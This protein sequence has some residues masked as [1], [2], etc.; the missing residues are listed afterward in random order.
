MRAFFARGVE[1]M[2][3]PWTVEAL[4]VLIHISLFLFFAGLA[5][6]LFNINHSAFVCVISWIGLFS[7]VYGWITLMPIFWYDSPYFTPLSSTAWFFCAPSRYI[8]F[9]RHCLID[10][11][12]SD[13]IL[14]F[15]RWKDLR[16]WILGG[17]EAAAKYV[18]S[19]PISGIDLGI[20][21]WTVG[22]LGED[23]LLER[24]FEV[25][26]GFF[27]STLV[28]FPKIDSKHHLGHHIKLRDALGGFLWRTMS[29][30]SIIESVK[31]RRFDI[32]LNAVNT[33]FEPDQV[34]DTLW[35]VL[36]GDFGQMPQNIV[37]V[38]TLS[39]LCTS[40][41]EDISLVGRCLVARALHSIQ[42]RDDRWIAL[43]RDQFCFPEH[44]LQDDVAHCDDSLLLY[45]VIRQTRRVAISEIGLFQL[46]FP[47]FDICN[48]L[49][50]LQNEFCALWDEMV[51]E[52]RV[53]RHPHIFLLRWIHPFYLALHQGADAA[54]TAFDAS[55]DL[56]DPSSYPL[57]NVPA[58][59]PNPAVPSPTQLDPSPHTPPLEGQ[60]IPS[61]RT[62]PQ[63][64][65][66][67]DIVPALLSFKDSVPTAQEFPYASPTTDPVDI[68]PHDTSLTGP[69]IHQPIEMVALDSN[70]LD[71]MMISHLSQP[72]LS[73]TFD[74]L[75][76][77]MPINEA[78][79]N[80]HSPAAASHTYPHHDPV[81]V[82]V[83]PSTLLRL[84]LGFVKQTGDFLS[85][86]SQ[87]PRFDVAS[88]FRSRQAA[89]YTRPTTCF[90]HR[91]NFAHS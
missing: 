62:S 15:F 37:T 81:P 18:A 68:A 26:P 36:Q 11:G 13:S 38:Y 5:V 44:A 85:L 70:P 78:G 67:A 10:H 84:P 73:Y 47:N 16:C 77:D 91:S 60:Q 25:I 1:K 20:L 54:P 46:S 90:G 87:F 21:D 27:S 35:K 63:Q 82:T 22:A 3:L 75:T 12:S 30:N 52:A 4:P 51:L 55:F 33:A 6:F 23:D 48:A 79:E 64:P 29:S 76:P 34:S 88:S 72:S 8:F 7:M 53:R 61:G 39:R 45:I 89:V 71:S 49:P 69:S 66:E 56:S 28:E 14:S 57:C 58:H 41:N 9:L 32:Y 80:S 17:V 19:D 2:H 42:E 65:K 50:E 31:N 24:F 83:H 43:A 74:G 59:H 86:R 40:N